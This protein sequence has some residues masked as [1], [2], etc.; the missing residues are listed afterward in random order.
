LEVLKEDRPIGS[1]VQSGNPLK[2]PNVNLIFSMV[3][4]MRFWSTMY[5]DRVNLSKV[6]R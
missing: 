4:L 6:T 2:S 1:S 5:K 3:T